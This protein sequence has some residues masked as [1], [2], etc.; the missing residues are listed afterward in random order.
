MSVFYAVL[1]RFASDT[2]PGSVP[3]FLTSN[4]QKDITL[5]AVE[6][7]LIKESPPAYFQHYVRQAKAQKT[8][9]PDWWRELQK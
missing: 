1:A 8:T 6:R 7:K 4:P 9:P 5:A 2:V 3:S